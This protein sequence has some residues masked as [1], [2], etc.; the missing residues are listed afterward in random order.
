MSHFT[1]L[2]A[3]QDDD[4]LE[5][6]LLPFHEYECTGIE[7]YIEWIDIHDEYL[8]KFN[9]EVVEVV[10]R[11]GN[12]VGTKYDRSDEVES[13]WVRDGIGISNKDQFILRPGYDLVEMGFSEYYDSF[14]QYMSDWCGYEEVDENGRFGY[15]TNPNSK[16]DWYSIGGRWTGKLKLKTIGMG[17]NGQPGLMT[18][19]N[20]DPNYADVAASGDVDWQGIHDESVQRQVDGYLLRHHYISMAEQRD[21]PEEIW[22]K[23]EKEFEVN[24]YARAVGSVYKLALYKLAASLA[25]DDKHHWWD[26][27]DDINKYMNMTERQYRASIV[28]EAQTYAFIDLYGNWQQRGEMG[29]FGMSDESGGT[30]NYDEAWWQFVKSLDDDQLVYVIDC[31]I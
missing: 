13:M 28:G 1:V 18:E 19:V 12:V 20:D 9:N 3:A 24:E 21:I 7:Q 15:W 2:V 26:T 23:S 5:Q 31:H 27:Y 16:W 14:A 22:E 4:D 17:R 30:D 29:W 11:N 25:W 8:D 10:L 6:K